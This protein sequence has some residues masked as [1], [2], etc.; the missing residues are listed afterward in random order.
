M[1]AKFISGSTFGDEWE[2]EFFTMLDK[3]QIPYRKEETL[4]SGKRRRKDKKCDVEAYIDD[5]SVFIELKT[6]W[7]DKAVEYDNYNH[8]NREFKSLKYHQI[9][10]MDYVI[11]KFRP[12]TKIEDNEI[13]RIKKFDFVMWAAGQKKESISLKNCREIGVLITDLEWLKGVKSEES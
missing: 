5:N 7:D 13:Y 12:H 8:P 11:I 1:K 10:A 6:S 4:S 9:K 3:A 2:E